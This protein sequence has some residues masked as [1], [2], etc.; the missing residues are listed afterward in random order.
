MPRA[1]PARVIARLR[2]QLASLKTVNAALRGRAQA[3]DPL[4]KYKLEDEQAWLTHYEHFGFV[5][6]EG[7][8]DLETVRAA[9]AGLDSQLVSALAD[10]LLSSGLISDKME[11]LP[12]EERVAALCASCPEQLPNL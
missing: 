12:F 1:R 10:R 4:T 6:L 7:V 2:A 9:Q 5:I 3:D 11:G 8:I